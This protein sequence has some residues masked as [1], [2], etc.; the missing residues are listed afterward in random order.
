[1]HEK[2]IEQNAETPAEVEQLDQ[3]AIDASELLLVTGGQ[4][5]DALH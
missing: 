3:L 1:M 5:S 2:N 4:F